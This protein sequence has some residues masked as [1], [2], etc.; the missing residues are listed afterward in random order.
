MLA[1]AFGPGLFQAVLAAFLFL[2]PALF[3]GLMVAGLADPRREAW[4]PP[5][6]ALAMKEDYRRV[7]RAGL[8][9]VRLAVGLFLVQLL[10]LLVLR[11][12][13][14]ATQ[15]THTMA[16]AGNLLLIADRTFFA[17]MVALGVLAVVGFLWGI[18]YLFLAR[19]E[20][21][22]D[23]RR[24]DAVVVHTFIVPIALLLMWVAYAVAARMVCPT[25]S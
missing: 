3:I 5:A 25:L 22:S 15:A 23:P 1:L 2:L 19:R 6:R 9:G 7:A 18:V 12:R 16:A 14:C 13:D 20:G 11:T 8:W 24:K 10:S 17:L 21:W 4:E